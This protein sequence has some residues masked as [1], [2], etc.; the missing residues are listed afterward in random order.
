MQFELTS[1]NDFDV[2]IATPPPGPYTTLA[3]GEGAPQPLDELTSGE[4]YVFEADT[5]RYHDG[6]DG[7]VVGFHQSEDD[8]IRRGRAVQARTAR[9]T[10]T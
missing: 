6:V 7:T 4:S 1:G 2:E 10:T 5:L 8:S 3:R 9:V